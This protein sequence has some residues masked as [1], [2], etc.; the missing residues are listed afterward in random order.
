MST[1]IYNGIK[2]KTNNI[3][4][5]LTQLKSIKPNIHN[6]FLKNF[7]YVFISEHFITNSKIPEKYA[8][9][10]A[11]TSEKIEKNISF[12]SNYYRKFSIIIIP[13]SNGELY[14]LYFGSDK[15]INLLYSNDIA[16]EYGYYNNSDQPDDITEEDWDTRRDVW[17]EILDYD[18]PVHAG[19]EYNLLGTSDF[20][21]Y[22][23]ELFAEIKSQGICDE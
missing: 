13:R 6:S 4:E 14:G 12:H 2:F 15:Y 22:Q 9:W 7:L 20:L 18:A 23:K 19:F 3:Y 11:L 21:K 8:I 10:H 17:D 5:L 16:V 1:K